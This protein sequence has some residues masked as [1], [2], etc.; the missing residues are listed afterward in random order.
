[1][2]A[3]ELHRDAVVIDGLIISNWG[4]PVFEDMVAGGITAANCTCSVWENFRDTMA[5]I[6]QWKRWFDEHGDLIVPVHEAADIERAKAAGKTGIILGW[7]NTSAIEDRLEFLELFRDLGVRVMQL[8][9]NTQNWVGTGCWESRD[10]GLSDFGRDAVAEMNRLGIVIDLSHVGARTST[11]AIEHS[12]RPVAYTHCCPS[13]LLDH[14]RNKTDAQLK[15]IAEAGGFVGVATY[16]WFLPKGADTTVDDA[17]D[18]VDYVIEVIGEDRVGIGADFTQGQSA[19]WFTWLRRDK[20]DGRLLMEDTG[21]VAP[22]PKGFERLGDYPNLTAAM[23]K[24]GWSEARCRKVLGANW[25]S[26]LAESW[27]V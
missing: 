9:Y 3:A 2:N 18:A 23:L 10:G 8:T 13:G 7:Q 21:T 17:L 15:E 19:E 4:R 24:R 27:Q 26:F 6:A 22:M 25:Q 1:M 20:G 5:N 12:K 16:P 14:P 11:D